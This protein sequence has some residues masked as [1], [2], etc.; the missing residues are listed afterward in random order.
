MQN[1]DD[2]LPTSQ[3]KTYPEAIFEDL[4]KF[5]SFPRVD[6]GNRLK[7]ALEGL[8]CHKCDLAEVADEGFLTDVPN[9]RQQA[10]INKNLTN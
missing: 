8:R 9:Q 10:I 7:T 3:T 6:L 5:Q 2:L 1:V 4:N